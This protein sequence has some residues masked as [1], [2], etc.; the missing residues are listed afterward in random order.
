MGTS[1]TA[2][3]NAVQQA[4]LLCASARE[5]LWAKDANTIAQAVRRLVARSHVV[6]TVNAPS[7]VTHHSASAKQASS[8][9]DAVLYAPST[10]ALPVVD[11]ESVSWRMDK[12]PANASRV[13]WE[14]TANMNA[15]VGHP[16]SRVRGRENVCSSKA[17][18][19]KRRASRPNVFARKDLVVVSARSRALSRVPRLVSER[20]NV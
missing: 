6:D 3:E 12:H 18:M 9:L 1:A 10:K 13:S 4:R 15:Q 8:V 5:A 19:E 20:E 7:T 11:R 14:L 2:M 16:L 17:E